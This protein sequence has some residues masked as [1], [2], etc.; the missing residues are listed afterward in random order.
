M[1]FWE[2]FVLF[3]LT[4]CKQNV[5][6]QMENIICTII[7]AQRHIVEAAVMSHIAS[8]F[9]LNYKAC[10]EPERLF[11]S[12]ESHTNSKSSNNKVEEF[13]SNE[14]VEYII[15]PGDELYLIVTNYTS[16][17]YADALP[18]ILALNPDIT[19]PDQLVVGQKLILPKT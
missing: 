1:D 14:C 10:I 8:Y 3:G 13:C 12:S 7:N 15:Q 11:S 18:K 19:H 9:G 6:F 2:E 5:L 4:K 16:I 17:P